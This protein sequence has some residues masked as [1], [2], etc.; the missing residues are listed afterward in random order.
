MD[1]NV[2]KDKHIADGLIGRTSLIC[3]KWNSI[4]NMHKDEE[5]DLY[6]R[7]KFDS[8][9]ASSSHKEESAEF[10]RDSPVQKETLPSQKLQDYAYK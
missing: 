4:K 9:L 3:V 2:Y 5:G 7:K 10:S 8:E 6:R 1:I